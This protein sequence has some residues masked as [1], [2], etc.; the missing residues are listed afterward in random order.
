[1]ESR[2]R[3]ATL[4]DLPEIVA[5]Y[6][7]TIASRIVTADTDPVTV[8]SRIPWFQAHDPNRRP[9]WVLQSDTGIAAW[10]SLSD[11]YGRPAYAATVEVAI[12]VREEER[13]KGQ[14]SILMEH[15][16]HAAPAL[17]ISTLLG[18]IFAENQASVRLFKKFAFTEWG[19]LPEVAR[20]D[21]ETR[22]LLILGRKLRC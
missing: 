3:L 7:S 14:A 10:L 18:F 19:S 20:L 16:I 4:E 12:Y 13:G 1:M 9:I 2:L 22:D 21:G 15:A 8:A 6:N 5:I 17:G 11:F